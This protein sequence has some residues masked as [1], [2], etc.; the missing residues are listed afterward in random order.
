M[1]LFI[2]LAIWGALGGILSAAS[3]GMFLRGFLIFTL[4]PLA[5]GLAA[6]LFFVG[7]DVITKKFGKDLSSDDTALI[8]TGLV[9]LFLI[10][11]LVIYS[12]EPLLKLL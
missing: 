8:S 11:P 9:F 2:L 5:I 6:G 12:L 10:A 1:P 7:M 4:P 3:G